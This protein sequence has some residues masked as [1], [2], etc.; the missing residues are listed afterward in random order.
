MDTAPG[1]K[2]DELLRLVI[3]ERE[4]ERRQG[5]P[6]IKGLDKEKVGLVVVGQVK[7]PPAALLPCPP[8]L[9]SLLRPLQ[10]LQKQLL[11]QQQHSPTD[12]SEEK[13]K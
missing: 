12:K 7:R 2:A 3:R 9:C 4:R 5:Q 1:G 8:R 13:V 6:Q 11:Q 10:P